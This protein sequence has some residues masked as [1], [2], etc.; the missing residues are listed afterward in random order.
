MQ[1]E[2]AFLSAVRATAQ[3]VPLI[4][5]ALIERGWAYPERIGIS[6]HS[7]G[8]FVTYAAVVTDKRIQVAAPVLGSPEWKLP[9]PE[10]P[11]LHLDKFFPTALL[12]QTASKDTR[13]LPDFARALHHQLVSC[14]AQAPE[15]LHYIEYP[16]SSHDLSEGDWEQAWN[17]A[18]RWFETFL[19]SRAKT[20][21]DSCLL[22]VTCSGSDHLHK[23]LYSLKTPL[24]ATLQATF[25]LIQRRTPTTNAY[26][27]LAAL[28]PS[29]RTA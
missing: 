20:V 27:L 12:S 26:P 4:I 1:L 18:A 22:V 15:R 25:L 2:A 21:L 28:H 9:W 5:D 19:P 13:V 24:N 29:A 23:L 11:H 16:N 10:S 3:E 8:G 14:Y 17:A 7:F 6:G